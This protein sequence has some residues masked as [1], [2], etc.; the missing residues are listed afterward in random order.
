MKIIAGEYKGRKLTAPPDDRI[1]PTAG[2]VKEAL[3]SLL[4]NDIAGST[5]LD[6]FSG[7]GSLGLEALSRGAKKCIFADNS[8][9]SLKITR[10]NI[11]HCKAEE[12]AEIIAGH[13][14]K[15]LATLDERVD[16]IIMDPPYNKGIVDE[17]MELIAEGDVLNSEG[18]VL[19]EHHADEPVREA[20]GNLVKVKEKR[21]GTIF[22][23][24]F[25]INN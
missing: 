7:T 13:Y 3:F 17:A 1:R 18:V 10:E 23:S 24:V 11:E 8:Q 5:V 16:V 21:Y 19:V 22:L 15:V 2:K 9:R 4:M 6:L 12:R 14:R 25:R 20:Y